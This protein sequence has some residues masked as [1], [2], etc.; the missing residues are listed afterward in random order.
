MAKVKAKCLNSQPEENEHD[1]QIVY[2]N[3]Y[4]T[5]W[6]L[7]QVLYNMLHFVKTIQ[8]VRRAS[9]VRCYLRSDNT[10]TLSK[11]DCLAFRTNSCSIS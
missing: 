5:R 3:M 8:K 7:Y 2:D 11:N 4:N 10:I 1:K 6:S 9:C